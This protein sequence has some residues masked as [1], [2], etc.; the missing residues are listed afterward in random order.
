MLRILPTFRGYT[1]DVRLREFRRFVED[2][3][4]H[5]SHWELVDF[6]SPLGDELFCTWLQTDG[7]LEELVR[8][9]D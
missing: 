7:A 1:V 5:E 4:T 2:P 8:C 3:N 6:D 9:G